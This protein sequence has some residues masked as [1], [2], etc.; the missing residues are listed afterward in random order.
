LSLKRTGPFFSSVDANVTGALE[1]SGAPP[2]ANATTSR[3]GA[4]AREVNRTRFKFGELTD[5]GAPLLT[6]GVELGCSPF[7]P[8]GVLVLGNFWSLAGV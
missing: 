2:A 3:L 6:T 8:L 1:R 4:L 5:F 7:R